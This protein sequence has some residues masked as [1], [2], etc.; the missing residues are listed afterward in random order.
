MPFLCFLA[1]ATSLCKSTLRRIC[2]L[3]HPDEFGYVAN[4]WFQILKSLKSPEFDGFRSWT[5]FIC[6]SPFVV[7]FEPKT[8]CIPVRSDLT[9]RMT[10]WK[11]LWGRTWDGLGVQ[12][13]DPQS[14]RWLFQY[15]NGHNWS[16]SD[17]L[18]IPHFRPIY[19]HTFSWVSGVVPSNRPLTMCL[20]KSGR[21]SGS[22]TQWWWFFC[23]SSFF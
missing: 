23:V 7:P 4:C 19:W 1:F 16:T 8:T 13:G 6:C 21:G 20:N 2:F 11:L 9:T 14:S 5:W 10:L 17:D 15:S 22:G 12:R 18:G 3:N